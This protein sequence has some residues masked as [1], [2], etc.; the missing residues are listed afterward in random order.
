MKSNPSLEL[1]FKDF[2]P[3]T[4]F[5]GKGTDI[6]GLKEL[7]LNSGCRIRK[8][9][10]SS[11]QPKLCISKRKVKQNKVSLCIAGLSLLFFEMFLL[12]FFVK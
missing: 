3:G 9:V 1:P 7:T 5:L 8:S 10:T 11:L 6:C 4:G 2:W 12:P